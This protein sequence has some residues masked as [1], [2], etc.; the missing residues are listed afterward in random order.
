MGVYRVCEVESKLW[1]WLVLT[2]GREGE[3]GNIQHKRGRV[4]GC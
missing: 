3:L 1:W 2:G 4:S